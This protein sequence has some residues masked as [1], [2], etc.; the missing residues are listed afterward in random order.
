MFEWVLTQVE[1]GQ[2]CQIRE[3]RDI[4][5]LI[6][7]EPKRNQICEI[8]QRRHIRDLIVPKVERR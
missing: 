8:A 5:N 2:I 6:R 7:V 4:G 1:L 3:R